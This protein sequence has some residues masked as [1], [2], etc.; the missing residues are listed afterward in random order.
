MNDFWSYLAAYIAMKML[1]ENDARLMAFQYKEPVKFAEHFIHYK[2][3]L[4]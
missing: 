1:K 4:N 2:I 3:P